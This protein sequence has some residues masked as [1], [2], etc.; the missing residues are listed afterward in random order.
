MSSLNADR[1]VPTLPSSLHKYGSPLSG[2][3][4][5]EESA[6]AGGV[7][8]EQAQPQP[9]QSR[10]QG[11]YGSFKS[12]SFSSVRDSPSMLGAIGV[13]P[14]A[15]ELSKKN[16][17]IVIRPLVHTPTVSR[18]FSRVEPGSLRGSIF[19][20]SS[21]AIGAGVL[22]LPLVMK[23]TGLIMGGGLCLIGAAL[24][25]LSMNMLVDTA[26]VVLFARGATGG[27][28]ISYSELVTQI[29]GPNWGIMLEITLVV[30]CFGTIVGYLLVIGKAIGGLCQAV[31]IDLPS[32]GFPIMMAACLALPLALFKDI[33]SL[34]LSSL[35]AITA[36]I[37][38]SM[39]ITYRGLESGNLTGVPE[40]YFRFGSDFCSSATIVF[41]AYN[42]HVNIFSIYSSLHYP[43]VSR[44]KKV[45]QRSVALE[46]VLYLSVSTSGYMLFHGDT[47]G[48][49]L[50]NFAATDIL[51]TVGKAGVA[52]ALTASL[53]LCLHPARENFYLLYYK[54]TGQYKHDALES[55]NTP[56]LNEKDST[57]IMQVKATKPQASLAFHVATTLCMMGGALFLALNVPGV[58]VVFSFLGATACVIICYALPILMY[59]AVIDQ[60][61][62]L[63]SRS[64]V[65]CQ[66]IGL[67]TLL[68]I[69]VVIGAI[70]A[71]SSLMQIVAL[72][73]GKE[74]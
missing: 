49:I 63:A 11:E 14:K 47:A 32:P 23:N 38:V 65:L 25:L 45:T 12:N 48:N 15:L 61:S 66:K 4:R 16:T 22:S 5:S 46:L 68:A 21:S 71:S 31:Q 6:A 39:S 2:S 57:T 29:L 60:R 8:Y 51:M 72:L 36:M 69:L 62:V 18:I 7:G 26:D 54:L 30:Y 37:Y 55:M 44:M 10:S 41:F 73:S 40:P 24:A 64:S 56:L 59:I 17:E 34:A 27:R 28:S 1:K 42:C 53:P 33:S 9:P 13:D 35:L 3:L 52:T 67:L 74:S 20:L 70:S 19:T 50:Q 43:L 58:S